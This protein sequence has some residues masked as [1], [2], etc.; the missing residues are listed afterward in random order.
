MQDFTDFIVQGIYTIN[1][2]N[3]TKNEDF[4]VKMLVR[5]L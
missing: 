2:T 5:E 4:T 3:A 1:I